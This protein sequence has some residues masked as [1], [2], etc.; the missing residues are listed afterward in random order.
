MPATTEGALQKMLT[1]H[2][3]PVGYRLPIGAASIALNDLLGATVKLE[4]LGTI[5]CIHCG[6]VTKKSFNQGYCFPCFRSL[7]Q[8]DSCIVSP[9][10][11]HYHEG[12]C[13]EPD[14]AD[15]Y[16]M[17]D[18]Y[19]YLANSSGVKA[20]ITRNNQIPTR[21]MDQGAVQAL[22]IARVASRR[23]SGLFEVILK[24]YVRDRTDWRTMLKGQIEPI[25]LAARWRELYP[26]VQANIGALHEQFGNAAVELLNLQ[27]GG[28][29]RI[30]RSA[31]P[32][33][34]SQAKSARIISI[35]TPSPRASC[36]A[37]KAS[38]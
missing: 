10:K 13:R 2:T 22:P 3:D 37:S 11:C 7:A 16:C 36:T 21:W 24:Q 6:R 25:D 17:R 12:T 35:R 14:W 18:H 26:A 5:N 30:T 9:E 20:G 4:F 28:A 27:P 34:I 8:C 23:L 19:V 15:D 29:R 33:C 38:I 32:C 1:A 31:I